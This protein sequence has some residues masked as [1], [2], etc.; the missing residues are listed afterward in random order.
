MR[1]ITRCPACQTQ[2]F[3][4]EDQL[5]K[6]NGKVR[7][8]QCL[9]V[10]DANTHFVASNTP[11]EANLIETTLTFIP[12]ESTSEAPSITS[13]DASDTNTDTKLNIDSQPEITKSSSSTPVQAIDLNTPEWPLI[14]DVLDE[15]DR[16]NLAALNQASSNQEST[17]DE[18]QLS[19]TSMDKQA[20]AIENHESNFGDTDTAVHYNEDDYI[21]DDDDFE[22]NNKQPDAEIINNLNNITKLTL[23]ADNQSNYFD[24]LA[25]NNKTVANPTNKKSRRWLWLVGA[26]ILLLMAVIQSIYFLRD[27]IA[28]YYPNVKPY[29]VK[30]CQQLNCNVN[31]PKQIDLI[32]IDDSDMQ[33][34]TNIT[35]LMHF[36]CSL[37]NQASF[38]QAFPNL[39]LTLTDVTD[40][41][42][43]RRVF[44]PNE[45]LPAN[46]N[47]ALG[48]K[49]GDEIKI[50]LGI[51]TQ[52]VAVAGYRVFVTY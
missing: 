47:V 22:D 33:E 42:T 28:I 37:F 13:T 4:S 51:T 23:I 6:H 34:D 14:N 12:V 31:L 52:G 24:D 38:T 45:Y 50:K 15:D 48:F 7:C 35:A 18:F 46:T 11:A 26:F 40:K 36:S 2:F 44:K 27:D 21:V 8:G 49:A 19:V 43:L 41:P 16:K 10:F 29:L 25:N 5:N 30:V 39:E 3:V 1:T 17:A 20:F 32:A 9:H